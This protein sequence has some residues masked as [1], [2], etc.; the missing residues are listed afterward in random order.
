MSPLTLALRWLVGGVMAAGGPRLAPAQVAADSVVYRLLPSSRFEVKTGKA[1]LF[2]FAGHSHLIRARAFTGRVVYDPRDPSASR[3]EIS[4]LADSLEVLTPPDTAE[5][6]KVTRTMLTDV[7]HTDQHPE[8]RFASGAVTPTPTGFRIVVKLTLVGQTRDVQVDAKVQAGADTLRAAGSFAAKQTDF[9]IKPY[10]GGPGGTV[11]V[12]DRVTFDFEA[13]GVPEAVPERPGGRWSTSMLDTMLRALTSPTAA[14]LALTLAQAPSGVA[15]GNFD[16]S[17]WDQLL[18]QHVIKGTVDYDA[19]KQAPEFGAY[20]ER[21]ASFDPRT[22]SDNE[23]LAFWINAYNAYTIQLILKHNERNSIRN[24]SRSI[25]GIKGY[26]PWKE[27]L[28]VVAG[29]PYGLDQIEQ[30]IIRREFREPRIHFALVCAAMGCAPLRSE[31][32]TGPRLAEQLDD[33]T[34]VFLLESPTKNRVDAANRAV[35]VSQLFKFRDYEKDFGGS[36]RAVAQFIARYYPPG[37]ERDLLESGTW[38]T[39]QYTDY[40]WTLNSQA[41]ARLSSVAGN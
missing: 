38:S 41:Q 1:G 29:T 15:Q 30:D 31:A 8:I 10:R 16:H 34:R 25:F 24:I 33:Q 7:L 12:A 3:L 27:K 21:L 37:P 13:V 40:D 28:A 5:I 39:W 22:L 18:K 19:F 4:V 2:G 14:L 9:G 23:R 35:Y 36:M 20:L 26:G 17:A 11:K 32:Y 6:R